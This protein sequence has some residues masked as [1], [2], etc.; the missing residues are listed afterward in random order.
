MVEAGFFLFGL[1]GVILVVHW[2]AVNDRAGN[3]GKTTG[4]FAMRDPEPFGAKPVA[5]PPAGLA[6][7]RRGQRA[8]PAMR[9][10][11]GF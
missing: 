9:N 1:L 11:R 2:A 4:L 10:R 7:H 3:Y 5:K 8:N 6:A